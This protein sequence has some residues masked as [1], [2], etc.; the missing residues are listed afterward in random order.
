[1]L[2]IGMLQWWYS[3][4]WKLFWQK[5]VDKLRN[6]ADF[7]SIRLLVQEMFAPFRQISAGEIASPSLGARISVFFDKLLSRLIGA[8]TRLFLLIMGIILIILEAIIGAVIAILWPLAPVLIV[9]C[10]VLSIMQVSF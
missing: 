5:F 1:M 3:E 6:A 10:I 8:V 7:F 4:G 2:M 9:G